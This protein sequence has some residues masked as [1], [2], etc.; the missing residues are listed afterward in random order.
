M[1]M[2]STALLAAL[3][4]TACGAPATSS[5]GGAVADSGTG[6]DAGSRPPAADAGE[7]DAGV[8]DAGT[9]DAGCARVLAPADAPRV[10]AVSHPFP[11]DGGSRD[12]RYELFTLSSDGTLTP[13]GEEFRM[14]RAS[15]AAGFITFT[16][17]GKVGLAPQD[18]G[19][20]GVFRVE[21][22]G[23]VTVVHAAY[24]GGFSAGQVLVE[25]SGARA[26][27]TDF[28]VQANGGG[29]Y[30]VDIGCDGSLSNPRRVLA[31]NNASAAA[32]IE[33]GGRA[34]VASRSL[35]TSP[36]DQDV[37]VADLDAGTVLASTTAFPD[38]DAI[39]PTV[40]IS[41]DGRWVAL[42]DTS[43][44]VPQQRVAF[45]ELVGGAPVARQ[46]LDVDSPVGVAFSPF[47][48]GGL[49]VQSDATDAFRR[50]TFNGSSF[51]ISSNTL[52]YA[53]GRPQL[54]TP[55]VV[56]E[57]GALRG[58][59][60]VGELDALRQLQFNQDGSITD[61]SKTKVSGSGSA[62]VVGSIGVS[63]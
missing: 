43:Y 38:R 40:S 33:P 48:S 36:V 12:N 35:G 1:R 45:L 46:V 32:W 14:R 26:W 50:V 17:D 62:Q 23:G 47:G 2:P 6:V 34:L 56:L 54:P 10:V 22:D 15:G 8:P 13:R 29:L 11:S 57:R 53:H 51:A 52:S 4:A 19:S 58:R 20:L 3:L 7:Q 42:P 16:P 60:L 27:V 61:V 59:V 30:S 37:H 5:D 21:A 55:P 41:A 9:V 28:N 25:P 44:F 31:G 49:L 24:A 18:D 63:P 39:P